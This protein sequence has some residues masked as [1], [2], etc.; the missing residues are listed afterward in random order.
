MAPHRYERQHALR[1]PGAAC[2]RPEQHGK[3][4]RDLR[5]REEVVER[6]VKR[7]AVAAFLCEALLRALSARLDGGQITEV[8]RRRE[9]WA[10]QRTGLAQVY[11]CDTVHKSQNYVR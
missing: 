2:R 5:L 4:Q 11:A 6:A 1:P 8:L 10:E 7:H 9:Q 3:V